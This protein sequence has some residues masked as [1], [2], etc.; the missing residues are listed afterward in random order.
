MNRFYPN[1]AF[2]RYPEHPQMDWPDDGGSEPAMDEAELANTI[3]DI[4]SELC[5]EKL[6]SHVQFVQLALRFR[7]KTGM[8]LKDAVAQAL[9]CPSETP[10]LALN[11]VRTCVPG[12]SFVERDGKLFVG[13]QESPASGTVPPPVPSVP[14]PRPQPQSLQ[15]AIAPKAVAEGPAGNENDLERFAYVEYESLL[16]A[17]AEYAEPE[18]WGENYWILKARLRALFAWSYKRWREAPAEERG[19]YLYVGRDCAVM[20]LGLYDRGGA[21]M[22]LTFQ[23]NRR[24]S[25]MWYLNGSSVAAPLMR[26]A[27]QGNVRLRAIGEPP[28]WPTF[29]IPAK[30]TVRNLQL[31]PDLILFRI[32]AQL[33]AIEDDALL[34]TFCQADAPTLMPA[35]NAALEARA[36]RRT[37]RT[38]L[39]EK[40][41]FFAETQAF[42]S[43]SAAFRHSI[44]AHEGLAMR[45]TQALELLHRR[46]NSCPDLPVPA[47]DQL[48]DAA[49]GE[50]YIDF[51]LPLS[52]SGDR[53]SV[54]I[55]FCQKDRGGAYV[56]KVCLSL[57]QSYVMARVIGRP[58]SSWLQLTGV[59]RS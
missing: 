19:R 32:I 8:R 45:I 30:P 15:P 59:E 40:N 2:D 18:T 23:P 7:Q 58:E 5:W 42:Q 20:P 9:G 49:S 46:L 50:N 37:A 16:P 12:L 22:F 36:R 51:L 48:I 57:N 11:F 13:K 52:L 38:P 26:L 17:I 41:A 24:L 3:A 44:V 6:C 35:C 54:A 34:R 55:A 39:Q 4:V 28:Q 56:P 14:P 10:S 25:P 21:E 27:V 43:L 1:D 53:L 33:R 31:D 29:P 47:Y